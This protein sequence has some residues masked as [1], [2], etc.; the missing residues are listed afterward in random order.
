MYYYPESL[1]LKLEERARQLRLDSVEMIQRRGSGHPGG[2]LSAAEIMAALF[3][4]KLRLDPQQPDWPE[5]DRDRK[6]V[7]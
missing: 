5:R 7:V 2:A 1:I 4:H 6:S 3:F